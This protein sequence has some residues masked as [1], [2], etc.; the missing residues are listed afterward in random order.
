MLKKE[1]TKENRRNEPKWKGRR[2]RGSAGDGHQLVAR[3]KC[4]GGDK[5]PGTAGGPNP[6]HLTPQML[7]H[8]TRLR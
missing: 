7:R 6:S 2:G 3:I 5:T 8:A 1:E 4:V